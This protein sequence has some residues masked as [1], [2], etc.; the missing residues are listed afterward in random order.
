MRA[1]A[2]V[3]RP[4]YQKEQATLSSMIVFAFC[5]VGRFG[6]LVAAAHI[7][8]RFYRKGRRTFPV[9]FL[10]VF[11]F[12]LFPFDFCLGSGESKREID[13]CVKQRV[14]GGPRGDRFKTGSTKIKRV[15]RIGR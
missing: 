1:C 9:L 11:H 6:D 2:S 15:R 14:V 13:E 5:G 4:H 8:N 10:S 7:A 12:F 3:H